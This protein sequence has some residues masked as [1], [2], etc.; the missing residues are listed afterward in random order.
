[1]FI[2]ILLVKLFRVLVDW[3]YNIIKVRGLLVI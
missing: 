1:M 2:L 3:E